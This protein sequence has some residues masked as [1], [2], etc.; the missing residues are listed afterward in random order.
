M[1]RVVDEG[2]WSTIAG[3]DVKDRVVALATAEPHAARHV[4]S[5]DPSTCQLRSVVDK[6]HLCVLYIQEHSQ[7]QSMACCHQL[8]H[9]V[10][11]WDVHLCSVVSNEAA[12]VEHRKEKVR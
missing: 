7:I 4:I 3:R 2:E 8:S 6:D 9:P 11:G 12:S 1:D 5:V 10:S